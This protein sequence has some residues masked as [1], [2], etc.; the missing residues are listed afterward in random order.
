MSW[1]PLQIVEVYSVQVKWRD[2]EDALQRWKE[3][4][5]GMPLVDA[6]M[7]EMAQTGETFTPNE[8]SFL[9]RWNTSYIS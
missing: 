1:A 9:S 2:D 6:N 3:G 4:R 7:R 8:L 5:T